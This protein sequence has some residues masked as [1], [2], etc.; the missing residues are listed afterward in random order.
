M[1]VPIG[2]GTPT[3]LASGQGSPACIV[4]DATS[5]YWTDFGSGAVMSTSKAG[6]ALVTL[7]R[8]SADRATLRVPET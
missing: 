5:V 2:G 1:K 6:G 7:V 4:I 8:L 3:T